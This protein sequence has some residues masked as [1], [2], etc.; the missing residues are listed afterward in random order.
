M[1]QNEDNEARGQGVLSD[2]G[3]DQSVQGIRDRNRALE[4]F[5]DRAWTTTLLPDEIADHDIAVEHA[6]RVEV[7]ALI[8]EVERLTAE[9][10]ALRAKVNALADIIADE[11]FAQSLRGLPV[12]PVGDQ[13]GHK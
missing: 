8:A 10:D 11:H 9:R 7:P 4:A 12:A 3:W 2:D 13:E 1:A 5:I 6:A